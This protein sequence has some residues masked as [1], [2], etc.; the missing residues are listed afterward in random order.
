MPFTGY[1]AIRGAGYKGMQVTEHIYAVKIPFTVPTG[2][3]GGIKRFVYSYVVVGER[4]AVIDAG[5]VTE[6]RPIFGEIAAAGRAVCD[7]SLL[8]L[9]HSHPDHIGGAKAIKESTGC[10]VAA[11]AD[12]R[13]WIEDTEAQAEARPVPGFRE[14]VEGPVAVDW[15]LRDG[16][17]LELGRGVEL[18]VLHTPG[19]SAG[20]ISLLCRAD[21]ALFTGD[22]V[23]KHGEVPVYEDLGALK[24]SMTRL[25]S[26]R[27]VDVVL[28]SWDEPRSGAD[29]RR[30]F[31]DGFGYLEQIQEIVYKVLEVNPKPDEMTLCRLAAVRLG[32]PET[33]INPITAR[34]FY[35]HVPEARARKIARLG[36]WDP[37]TGRPRR[38]AQPEAH[39]THA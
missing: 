4:V 8:V 12:E 13:R 28:P 18:E 1:V 30:V 20:S 33:A 34:S 37:R 17:V 39:M 6:D 19:H 5:V 25:Q 9:T 27:D 26:L 35:A 14:L 16:D 21:R 22:A 36:L 15:T 24:S 23:P 32:L 11:H 38:A 3:N 29:A 10:A 7:L 2:R 31:T